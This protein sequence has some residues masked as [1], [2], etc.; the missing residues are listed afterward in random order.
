MGSDITLFTSPFDCEAET[1]EEMEQERYVMDRS[2]AMG[3][4]PLLCFRHY[5][6]KIMT[7]GFGIEARE[8]FA[9]TTCYVTPFDLA[10]K[11]LLAGVEIMKKQFPRASILDRHVSYFMNTLIQCKNNYLHLDC[12][13]FINVM[14]FDLLMHHCLMGIQYP[15]MKMYYSPDQIEQWNHWE[16]PAANG[17]M[18]WSG[19]LRRLTRLGCCWSGDQNIDQEELFTPADLQN[20]PDLCIMGFSTG[21]PV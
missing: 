18:T 6:L 15:T 9:P 5:D 13:Q 20:E 10:I 4:L 21:S 1:S 12:I 8:E 16:K 2:G 14:E 17:I 7:S 19:A 11:Q 3:L